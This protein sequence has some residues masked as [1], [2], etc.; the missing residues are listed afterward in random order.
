M[1]SYLF[2]WE[3]MYTFAQ[4]AFY[5]FRNGAYAEWDFLRGIEEGWMPKLPDPTVASEDVYG[6]CLDI[7]NKTSDDYKAIVDEF[8]DPR[9]LDWR[10]SQGW[11]ATD[12]FVLSDPLIPDTHYGEDAKSHVF[13]HGIIIVTIIAGVWLVSRRKKFCSMR[14]NGYNELK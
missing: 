14:R 6:T 5:Y 10:K 4:P 13:L 2:F 7:Y 1:D 8:P 11:V 12:D 9:D 3:K